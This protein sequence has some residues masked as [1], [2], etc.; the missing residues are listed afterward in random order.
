MSTETIFFSYSRDDTEF[1]LQLAKNLRQ[2][3]ANVWLDQLDISPGSRWDKSIQD[4]LT[5][6]K[7]LLVILSKTSVESDNVLDEVSFALEE[8]KRVVPVLLEVCEIPFRL[9]RLQYADF[10]EHHKKGIQ[11][12]IQTLNLD[13][14]A[15]L[16]LNDFVDQG[17]ERSK[18]EEINNAIEIKGT[19]ESQKRPILK[20]K[21]ADEIQIKSKET[22]TLRPNNNEQKPAK[23]KA[24]KKI[25]LGLFVVII[26]A[27]TAWFGRFFIEDEDTKWFDDT[28]QRN[29]VQ[30]FEFYISR[31]PEGKYLERAR[32]SVF[33]KTSREK[34]IKEQERIEKEEHAWIKAVTA[35][36]I[37]GF[38]NYISN[39]PN[40]THM[41]E[42]REKINKF[43]ENIEN[44][45]L[46][47]LAW[48][49]A[50]TAS[51]VNAYLDYY[52][53]PA[54]LGSHCEEALQ[55]IKETGQKGWLYCGRFSGEMMTES[56]FDLIWRG[57][58]FSAKDILKTKDIVMLKTNE[59]T[60]RTYRYANNR[61][62]NN[63]NNAL[64]DKNK[65]MYVLAVEKEG[66]ALVVQIIY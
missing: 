10:T 8:G 26:L 39:Y 50:V 16:K 61:N 40:G 58:D 6:S 64:I 41:V 23:S 11:T 20:N 55:K 53:N 35:D 21:A 31:F 5:N 38:Q 59:S 17:I 47:D 14:E 25:F 13:T 42:A 27:S 65:K 66:N 44:V 2:A 57:E 22:A 9:R 24:L 29:T 49:A 52:T 7:V 4:A 3:G 15:A 28:L 56:I 63:A 32:D 48:K 30:D 1:V 37:E 19:I 12:L 51:T 62:A 36:N 46:D 60:R 43:S 33:A 34:R 45:R 18:R 54:V